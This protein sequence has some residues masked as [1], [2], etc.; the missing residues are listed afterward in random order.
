M[1]KNATFTVCTV[2]IFERE[3][4]FRTFVGLADEHLSQNKKEKNRERVRK[5]HLAKIPSEQPSFED[6][7][8]FDV[9]SSFA[10]VDKDMDLDSHTDKMLSIIIHQYCPESRLTGDQMS[11]T[12]TLSLDRRSK[13]CQLAYMG[14][15]KDDQRTLIT[16][17]DNKCSMVAIVANS[18][19]MVY[20]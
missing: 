2:S 13:V 14:T 12:K 16:K 20:C 5:C 6:L 8:D 9:P 19:H 17:L 1:A 11:L 3:D 18:V 15:L 10:S 4:Y 7:S